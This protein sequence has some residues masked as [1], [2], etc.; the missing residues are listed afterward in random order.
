MGGGVGEEDEDDGDEDDDIVLADEVE[1]DLLRGGAGGGVIGSTFTLQSFEFRLGDM[2]AG[3]LNVFVHC[4]KLRTML[5][6]VV[7][8]FSIFLIQF[9]R[10]I[11]P[12]IPRS[13]Y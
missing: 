13:V 12:S 8:L 10:L 5:H 4:D 6:L 9:N 11:S 7:G 3:K 2:R 1:V